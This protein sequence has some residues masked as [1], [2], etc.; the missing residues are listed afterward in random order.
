MMERDHIFSRGDF[1]YRH[2]VVF[3]QKT[4]D[5]NKGPPSLDI[6]APADLN[7]KGGTDGHE[8]SSQ[9]CEGTIAFRTG[10]D[11]NSWWDSSVY[12]QGVQE[13]PT[14]N[15]VICYEALGELLIRVLLMLNVE[16]GWYIPGAQ[17]TVLLSKIF[18]IFHN[19]TS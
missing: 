8:S 11:G 3:Q 15:S 12:P 14:E 13:R 18:E 1:G 2:N 6:P 17:C 5:S 19:E 7:D 10:E 4:G 16:S 9:L